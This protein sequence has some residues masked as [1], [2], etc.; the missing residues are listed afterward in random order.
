MTFV[1]CFPRIAP[2][3]A[4]VLAII[5]LI[6]VGVLAIISKEVLLGGLLKTLVVII[7]FAL[8]II[9]I[10]IICFYNNEIKFQGVLLDYARRFLNE[11]PNTFLYIP[12]FILLTI[13]LIAL[14][15]FQHCAFSSSK[16]S[17]SNFF[18]FQNPGF[19][20]ILNILEFIW[21]LQF[22]R[23]ACKSIFYL[24]NF[25]VSGN[26]VD[27]YWTRSTNCTSSYQRLL[28]K[29]WGSVVAGSFLNA[30]FE[31][32]TLIVELLVCHPQTCCAKC[33]TFCLNSCNCCTS[34]FNLVRTDA[35]SYINLA[36]IPFCNSAR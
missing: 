2:L 36:G 5:L 19:L 12:L 17:S 9:L 6:I 13:G 3:V 15:T 29:N 23:D 14:I 26:A 21:G 18:N 27:W 10:A 8:V 33:G 4:F 20:G 24:V 16:N 11:S 22:L 7:C 25:C 30:F 31:I 34:F 35:Y 1:H 28:C 32:P